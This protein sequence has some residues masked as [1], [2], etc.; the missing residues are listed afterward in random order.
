MIDR[1]ISGEI[2]NAGKDK[3]E[4]T[5]GNY[6]NTKNHLEAYQEK[7]RVKLTFESITLD[8]FYSYVSFLKTLNGRTGESLSHNTKAMDIKNIKVFMSEAIDLNY[9]K[10]WSSSVRNFPCPKWM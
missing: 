7:N 4:N 1:F 5:L 3:S 8:F 2:K 9:T 10:T 6:K